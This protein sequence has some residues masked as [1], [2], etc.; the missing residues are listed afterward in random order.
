MVGYDSQNNALTLGDDDSLKVG[1]YELQYD[2]TDD[3]FQAEYDRPIGGELGNHGDIESSAKYDERSEIGDLS[4]KFDG[5]TS[6]VTA[7]NSLP[8]GNASR[9]VSFWVN[10]TGSG[11]VTAHGVGIA[12]GSFRVGI[13]AYGSQEGITID[14][15]A[16]AINY[17]ATV[18]DGNWHHVAVV[19]PDITDATTSD[20][21]PY[22]DGSELTTTGDTSNPTRILNTQE[23]ELFIGQ[24]NDGSFY[25]GLV[26]DVR[27]YNDALTATEA[28]NL[29]NGS[30]VTAGLQARYNF[31]Y[32]ETPNVAIDSTGEV[33]P[34]NS[35]PRS[36]SGSLVPQGFADVLSQGE[37]LA[38]NGE[39]YTSVQ[40]A[41]DNSTGF[42]FVGPG[43][44][45]ESVTISTQGMTLQGSGYDTL[46][47]GGT[48]SNAITVEASDAT[49]SNLSAQNT[50]GEGAFISAIRSESGSNSLTIHSVTIRDSDHQGIKINFGANTIIRDCTIKGADSQGIVVST[51]Q[52]IVSNCFI[53]D[54]GNKSINVTADDCIVTNCIASNAGNNGIRIAGNDCICISN[55]V[56]NAS[57]FGIEIV[58][59]SDCIVAN[60]RISDSGNAGIDDNASNTLLDDNLTGPSN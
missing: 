32:P 59:S 30:D 9:S 58:N 34:K 20:I 1:E 46:I 49:I 56:S 33:F 55:R 27:T 15:G 40:T 53:S 2:K 38:D 54:T 50:S 7:P 19:I 11:F 23:S 5:T 47:D 21:I 12:G 39:I 45:N 57:Y 24:F 18:A 13:S 3:E 48:G 37:V 44:F 36:T 4:L 42:V 8:T 6:S 35:I 29:S 43:T 26:D 14:C 25:D 51:P 60:N 22:L 52:S 16:S 28:N 31:E 10:T 41:V 17:L